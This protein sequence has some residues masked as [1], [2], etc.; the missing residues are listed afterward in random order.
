MRGTANNF[1]RNAESYQGARSFIYTGAL[2]A[3]LAFQPSPVFAQAGV[4]PAQVQADGAAY[5]QCLNGVMSTFDSA[6]DKR[7]RIA[8]EC[9]AT[10]DNF[11]NGF[12]EPL[13][14]EVAMDLDRR[15]EAVLYTLAEIE[16]VVSQVS[17]EVQA[18]V[19]EAT[20]GEADEA[21]P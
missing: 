3:V 7:S 11:V 12:P 4:L 17:E 1:I 21:A 19:P 14:A 18:S 15:V 8:V 10:R 20:E 6:A 16:G 2:C 5:Q 13:R 9:A